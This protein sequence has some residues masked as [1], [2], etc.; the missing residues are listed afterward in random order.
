MAAE[1]LAMMSKISTNEMISSIQSTS[2]VRGNYRQQAGDGRNFAQMFEQQHQKI[3]GAEFNVLGDAAKA[4]TVDERMAGKV[5]IYDHRG[6][7][8]YFHMTISMT[9]LKG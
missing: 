7:L 6:M 2:R 3:N 5:N 8:N 1:T 9:D 4:E